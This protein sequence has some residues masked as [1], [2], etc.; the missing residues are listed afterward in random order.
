MAELDW[1]VYACEKQTLTQY[2]IAHHVLHAAS[3]TMTLVFFGPITGP[4]SAHELG[5]KAVPDSAPR[6]NPARS[7]TTSRST[8]TAHYRPLSQPPL[9]E[10]SFESSSIASSGLCPSPARFP[11]SSMVASSSS[12]CAMLAILEAVL[13][14]ENLRKW[15][16]CVVGG[17]I[18]KRLW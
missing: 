17:M 4:F 1:K 2:K 11:P 7:I 9:Q 8:S 13:L 18:G 12:S 10:K 15:K 16:V 6:R 5:P 3:R 14:G